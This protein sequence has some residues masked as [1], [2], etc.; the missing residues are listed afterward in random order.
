M[1]AGVRPVPRFERRHLHLDPGAPREVSHPPVGLDAEHRAAG[2]LELPG[3][4]AGAAADVQQVGAGGF[5]ADPLHKGIGVPGP[6][7]VVAFSVCAE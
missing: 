3:F 6:G 5:R 1:F 7:P 4:D 2:R